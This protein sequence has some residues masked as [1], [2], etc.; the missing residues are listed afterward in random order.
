MNDPSRTMPCVTAMAAV[1]VMLTPLGCSAAGV[2]GNHERLTMAGLGAVACGGTEES[3]PFAEER[4]PFAEALAFT[5]KHLINPA[6]NRCLA[7]DPAFGGVSSAV[8]T[9][10]DFQLWS[11]VGC[12]AKFRIQTSATSPPRCLSYTLDEQ[13]SPPNVDR[14]IDGSETQCCW[15]LE[16]APEGGV[17]IYKDIGRARLYLTANTSRGVVMTEAPS[18][19]GTWRTF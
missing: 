2:A 13:G 8:C 17:R 18:F 19:G 1:L 12:G 15:Q 5:R 3:A 4:A 7:L 16:D 6:F 10:N 11:A 9:E 14:C